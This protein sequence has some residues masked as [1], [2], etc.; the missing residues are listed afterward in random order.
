MILEGRY[1]LANRFYDDGTV[2]VDRGH[3]RVLNRAVSVVQ[4]RNPADPAMVASFLE[5]ARRLATVELPHAAALFDQG[6]SQSAPYLICEEALPQDVAATA[7]LPVD[8]VVSLF[9][10]LRDTLRDAERRNVAPPAFLPATVRYDADGHLQ[11]LPVGMLAAAPPTDIAALGALLAFALTGN[12]TGRSAH[13]VPPPI[14][15]V[16]DRSLSAG[17]ATPDALI[18]DLEQAERQAIAPTLV[19]PPSGVGAAVYQRP[20]TPQTPLASAN[21]TVPARPGRVVER[22]QRVPMRGRFLLGALILVPLLLVGISRIPRRASGDA[23][24]VAPTDQIPTATARRAASATLETPPTP[25]T[26]GKSFVVG[27]ANNLPLN[28]RQAPSVNA[29]VVGTIANGRSVNVYDAPVQADGYTWAHI[30]TDNI[31]G[32]GVLGAL[33]TP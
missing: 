23:G 8:L 22:L 20:Q 25:R 2:V 21:A 29:Q 9:R 28:V 24:S 12:A 3:D 7:P 15:R 5:S 19:V 27:T 31:D 14:R 10:Q 26:G 13:A 11:L 6:E 30:V 16:I 4:L 17:Y 33:H 18:A 32:W 1:E